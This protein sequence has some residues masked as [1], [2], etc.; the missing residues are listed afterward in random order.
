MVG[1]GCFFMTKK[2]QQSGD[3]E[4]YGQL[5]DNCRAS[6]DVAENPGPGSGPNEIVLYKDPD[7]GDS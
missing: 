7:S 6:G 5:V 2:A 4:V 1:I 3:Q